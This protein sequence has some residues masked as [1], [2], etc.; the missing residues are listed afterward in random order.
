MLYS[1]VGSLSFIFKALYSVFNTL[2]NL[3]TF[4][5]LGSPFLSFVNAYI[6]INFTQI[7]KPSH[8][9][10]YQLLYKLSRLTEFLDLKPLY[11]KL[12]HHTKPIS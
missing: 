10:T 1:F 9:N 4:Q 7:F 6:A 8:Y 3:R 5:I 2:T 12:N 11:L